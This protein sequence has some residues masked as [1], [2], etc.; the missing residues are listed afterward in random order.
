MA[1]WDKVCT[2][3]IEVRNAIYNEDG[4]AV[5]DGLKEICEKYSNEDWDFAQDFQDLGDDL[6]DADEDEVDYWLDEFYDL[7]DNA[8][9]W[10]ELEV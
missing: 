4:K 3:F 6:H 10:L 9:V 2:E 5:L 8:R 1:R 7:C